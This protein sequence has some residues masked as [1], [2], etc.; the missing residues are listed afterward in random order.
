VELTLLNRDRFRRPF[1][2]SARDFVLGVGC[3]DGTGQRL[4]FGGRVIK[5]VA[6]YDVSRLMCGAQG[7]L[8]VVL[9]VALKLLPMPECEQSLARECEPLQAM[10]IMQSLRPKPLPLAG[11][12]W[13]A[14]VLRLRLEG[15]GSAVHRAARELGGDTET[16]TGWW[17]E[18]RDQRLPFFRNAKRLWRVALP[19]TAAPLALDAAELIDWSGAQRW[20]S[21]DVDAALVRARA[22]QLGGHASD[23]TPGAESPFQPLAPGMLAL[24]LQLKQVFDPR[25]VLNPG[26]LYREL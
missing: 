13:D 12:A 22:A 17:Q 18:L 1:A 14:G 4:G 6:G 21:G 3:I 23:C 19:P 24:Q 20:L 25:R 26:R 8:G 7:T 2:G 10:Q 5:N 11:A 9:D 15:S 16:D